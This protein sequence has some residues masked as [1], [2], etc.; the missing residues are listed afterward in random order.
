MIG[1]ETI[2][3]D[4]KP[5]DSYLEDYSCSLIYP[6][7]TKSDAVRMFEVLTEISSDT[8]EFKYNTSI[9]SLRSPTYKL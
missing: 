5:S 7:E 8:L 2:S 9:F 4:Y 6:C 1:F 3:I